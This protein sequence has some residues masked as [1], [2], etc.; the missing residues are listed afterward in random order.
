MAVATAGTIVKVGTPAPYKV[1]YYE[2]ILRNKRRGPT[3]GKT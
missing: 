3:N 2:A 1:D